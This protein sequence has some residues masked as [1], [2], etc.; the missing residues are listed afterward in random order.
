MHIYTRLLY[1]D[2]RTHVCPEVDRTS[3]LYT[4]TTAH[5]CPGG[6]HIVSCAPGSCVQATVIFVNNFAF[7]EDLNQRLSRHIS[8]TCKAGTRV[9]T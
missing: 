6:A 2:D 7:P 9:V 8:M 1:P 5:V 3:C 4:R